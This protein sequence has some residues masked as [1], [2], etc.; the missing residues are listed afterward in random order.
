MNPRLLDGIEKLLLELTPGGAGHDNAGA[1]PIE[2][3]PES[4]RGEDRRSLAASIGCNQRRRMA[5][6]DMAKGFPLPLVGPSSEDAFGKLKDSEPGSG[7]IHGDKFSFARDLSPVGR[8]GTM[9]QNAK[10]A[11]L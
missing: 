4:G 9:P 7:S 8:C 3:S 5:G 2:Q 6:R 10:Y 11:L 1:G